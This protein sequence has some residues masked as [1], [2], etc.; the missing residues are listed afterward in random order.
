MVEIFGLELDWLS[1][2]PAFFAVILSIYNWF[3]ANKPADIVPNRLI[4]YALVYSG[5]QEGYLMC[6]PL[7]FHNSGSS[8]GMITD[9]K[10]GFRFGDEI[11][12][13]DV[14]SKVKL[15]EMTGSDSESIAAE[16]FAESGYTISQP[17]F[18]IEV[19]AGG[20]NH[21]TIVTLVPESENQIPFGMDSE[22]VIEVEFGDGKKNSISAPFKISKDY[23]EYEYLTWL[24]A[25]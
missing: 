19:M 25:I 4:S 24:K 1:L 6:F 15:T 14:D 2:I 23:Q 10:I 18:P 21:A 11:K 20:S 5:A 9:I 8:N 13:I 12:Y 3:M 16:Q 17:F 7:I 22:C